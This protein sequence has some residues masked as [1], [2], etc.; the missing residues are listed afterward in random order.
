MTGKRS[1]DTVNLLRADESD[2]RRLLEEEHV[3]GA[4]RSPS[5]D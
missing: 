2:F 4:E 1:I 5:A 3:S